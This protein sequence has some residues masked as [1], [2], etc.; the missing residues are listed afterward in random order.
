MS[1]NCSFTTVASGPG[2]VISFGPNSTASC[3][4]QRKLSKLI[5][6]NPEAGDAHRR[7]GISEEALVGE[8]HEEGRFA[9]GGVAGDDELEHVVPGRARNRFK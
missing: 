7:I 2:S 6:G 4:R 3:K 9:G 8:A 1:Q 5:K